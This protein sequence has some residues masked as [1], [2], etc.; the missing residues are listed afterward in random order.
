MQPCNNSEPKDNATNC[1]DGDANVYMI[2]WEAPV[3]PNGVILHYTLQYKQ[4]NV[5]NVSGINIF[6]RWRLCAGESARDLRQS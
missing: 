5:E 2:Y 4:A 3:D 6:I 1:G